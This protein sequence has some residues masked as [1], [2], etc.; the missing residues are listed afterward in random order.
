MNEDHSAFYPW[1]FS[2]DYPVA[3]RS[4]GVYIY[5]ESGKRYLDGSGGAVAVNIGH[6]VRAVTDEIHR[7]LSDLPYTHTSHFR[8][9]V[10]EELAA[11]LAGKFPG[12]PQQAKVLFASGGSEATESAIKLVRQYW[13]ARNQPGRYRIISRWHGYHGA[14][15]GALGLS[16]NRRRRAP[17]LDLLAPG[18]HIASCFCYHCP[19][20]REFPSCDL[21][22]AHEL[23]RAILEAGADTVAGFILEPIVGATSG[24]VPPDGYL[25]AI[26]EICDRYEIP[27]IADEIMTGSGRTGRYF[28]VE[29]WGVQPDIILMGKGLSSGYAPLGA[30]LVA[31]HIWQPI[32]RA[33]ASLEHS[34]TYQCHPPSMAA[35]LAVQRYLAD[36]GLVEQA[37]ERGDYLRKRLM[38]LRSLAC[39]GDVRGLGLMWTVEFLADPANRLPFAPQWQFS[40]RLFEALRER[41][42]MLYPG[43]GTIDG[44]SGD[45]ILI[46]P[47]FIIEPAQIDFMVEMLKAAIEQVAAAIAAA[48]AGLG[49]DRS[50]SAGLSLP[51]PARA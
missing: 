21:A 42:V 29:H 38:N 8:T 45:H 32:R 3:V 20:G 39:V 2:R 44:Q 48:Q 1:S 51:D 49:R 19:L 37:A 30:V 22:C 34:F 18:H 27:L 31:E 12:P 11:F 26:R 17:Y 10:G 13:L 36:N 9:R 23:E 7:T 24:A 5:D 6:S 16:G 15:L 25:R 41:G 50:Q 43:R 47:P 28:A 4:E 46:A 40:E 35:G 14:T 33:A